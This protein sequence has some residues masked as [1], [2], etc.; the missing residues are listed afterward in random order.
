MNANGGDSYTWSTGDTNGNI[1]VN[2][3]RTTTYTLSAT[4]GGTT[5]IDTVTVTVE[6]CNISSLQQEDELINDLTIYPNP[7]KGVLNVNLSSINNDL[8]LVLINLNGSVVYSNKMDSNQGE[9]SK[10]LDLS[11]FAKGV[12]FVRLFNSNT[13]MVKKVIHI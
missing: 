7:T 11:R 9:L 10:Q 3:T 2:P 5:D 13:N 1:E 4:R 8:N 12:Y 6:N